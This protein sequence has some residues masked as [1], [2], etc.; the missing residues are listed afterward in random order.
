VGVEEVIETTKMH[1][2]GVDAIVGGSLDN[3]GG[4]GGRGDDCHENPLAFQTVL[5][6]PGLQTIARFHYYCFL[7]LIL[8][9][10]GASCGGIGFGGALGK[11]ENARFI[12]QQPPRDM[13]TFLLK[14]SR[15]EMPLIFFKRYRGKIAQTSRLSGTNGD[16]F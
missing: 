13:Y 6:W 16:S 14:S 8:H 9:H 12:S 15:R 3:V 2:F 11:V 7:R 5:G 4:I 10:A 1:F